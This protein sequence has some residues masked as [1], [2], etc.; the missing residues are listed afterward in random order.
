MEERIEELKDI[1]KEDYSKLEEM[2]RQ[3]KEFSQSERSNKFG[4]M[5]GSVVSVH[6]VEA[7]DL[8]PSGVLSGTP[9][10]YVFV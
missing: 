8:R 1:L 7:R 3:F 6:I 2:Q 10:P 4:V 5:V 9:N